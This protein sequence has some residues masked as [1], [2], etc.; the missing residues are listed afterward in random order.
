MHDSDRPVYLRLM[1][2]WLESS[3][4]KGHSENPASHLLYGTKYC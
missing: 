1:E 2:Q 3:R 4:L